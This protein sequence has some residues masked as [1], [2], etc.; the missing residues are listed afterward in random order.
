WSLPAL[1][2]TNRLVRAAIG[3]WQVT[4]IATAQTGDA[5]TVVAGAD[6]S[7]TGLNA[8]RGVQVGTAYGGTA[9]TAAAT[10]VNYLNPAAFQLPA[11]GAFG[12]TGKGSLRGPGSFN[13]DMGIF[14]R[15]PLGVERVQLQVRAEYFNMLNHTR[16]NDP[17]VSLSGAGF[18]QILGA[19]EPR[20]GQLLLSAIPASYFAR[21]WRKS[22]KSVWV[23][24]VA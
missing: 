10:C 2:K 13:W 8:D 12:N 21:I 18:G 14:K 11:T 3:R 23:G 6:Q 24:T 17:G 19:Q 1:T 20:I 9:C 5:L 22:T 16:F 4:G 15:F 7:Q